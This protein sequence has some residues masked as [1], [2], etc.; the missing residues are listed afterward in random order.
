[1]LITLLG[2]E[3]LKIYDTFTFLTAQAADGRKIKV[4]NVNNSI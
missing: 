4:A 2:N 1:M 3:G